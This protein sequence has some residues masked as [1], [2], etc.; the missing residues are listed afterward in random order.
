MGGAEK[1]SPN[2]TL[3]ML[4]E[5]QEKDAI[6]EAAENNQ[7]LGVARRPPKKT[8]PS[9]QGHIFTVDAGQTFDVTQH[10]ERFGE[11][12]MK[13]KGLEKFDNCAAY[14]LSETAHCALVRKE[15]DKLIAVATADVPFLFDSQGH[16]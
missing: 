5:F 16:P 2:F 3:R 11:G 1:G 8:T 9:R 10:H 13:L 4:S 15:I 6:R 7:A 14:G 12:P